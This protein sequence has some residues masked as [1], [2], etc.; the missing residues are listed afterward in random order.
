[1]IRPQSSMHAARRQ[2]AFFVLAGLLG[3]AV[4]SAIL[5][6][7]ASWLGFYGARVLSF[8][9]AATTTWA[10]NRRYTFDGHGGDKPVWRQYL[11]YL[12]SMTLGGCVNYAAY[13]ATLQWAGWSFAPLLGVAL[14]SLAGMGFN[15]A[16]ARYLV[17]RAHRH[18][19]A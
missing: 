8:L 17:F 4:D 6:A 19:H 3:L 13:A 12:A 2:L 14:G 18:P 1:M 11:Q 9:A 16:S 5:Y 10:V 7:L 15:F